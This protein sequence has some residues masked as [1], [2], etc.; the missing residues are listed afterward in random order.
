[1]GS[2]NEE[3]RPDGVPALPAFGC[4]GRTFTKLLGHFK[5]LMDAQGCALKTVRSDDRAHRF[6]ELVIVT[7][8]LAAKR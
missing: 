1:M 8:E 7:G 5:N 4:A 3:A 2:R 6:K